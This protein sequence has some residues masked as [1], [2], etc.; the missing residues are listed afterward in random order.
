ME[1]GFSPGYWGIDGNGDWNK[2]GPIGEPQLAAINFADREGFDWWRE[3]YMARENYRDEVKED[4]GRCVPEPQVGEPE[5][6]ETDSMAVEETEW[7][8]DER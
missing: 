6:D 3:F 1:L 8:E 2:L 5:P 7:E 4:G